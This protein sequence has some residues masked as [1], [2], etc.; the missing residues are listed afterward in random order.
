VRLDVSRQFTGSVYL[1]VS[2]L[3]TQAITMY[4]RI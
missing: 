2:I 4:T 3:A 1:S